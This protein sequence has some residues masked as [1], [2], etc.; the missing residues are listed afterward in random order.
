MEHLTE[1]A[2]LCSR[3][4]LCIEEHRE[5]ELAACPEQVQALLPGWTREEAAELLSLLLSSAQRRRFLSAVALPSCRTP[6][7]AEFCQTALALTH[8]CLLREEEEV[9][10]FAANLLRVNLR[11]NAAEPELLRQTAVSAM[12][13]LVDAEPEL[14][15][16][17]CREYLPH[18]VGQVSPEAARF[19]W[20]FGFSL[21]NCGEAAEAAQH[22]RRCMEL[23][24]KTEGPE[25]WLGA[26]AA[27]AWYSHRLAAGDEAAELPLWNILDGI[28][29]SLYKGMDENAPLVANAILYLVLSTRM[30]KQELRNFLPQIRRFHDFC[31]EHP[32]TSPYFTLRA[33]ENFLS[34]YHMEQGD[35]LQAARHAVNALAARPAEGMPAIPDDSL[36]QSNLLLIYSQ[37]GDSDQTARLLDILLEQLDGMDEDDPRIYRLCVLIHTTQ[38]RLGLDTSEQLPQHR[39][40]LE[41]YADA[42]ERGEIPSA[43]EDAVSFA[44]WILDLISGIL[45]EGEAAPHELEL[46]RR[47]IRH[48]LD[49]PKQ[50]PFNRVQQAAA[51]I[52]QAQVLQRLGDPAVEQALEQCLQCS[53]VLP[54]SHEVR[55]GGLRFAALVY[56]WLNKREK[57]KQ[58]VTEALEGVHCAWQKAMAYLND[59]KLYQLLN[60]VQLYFSVCCSLICICEGSTAAYEQVLRFKALG[61]RAGRERN[62]LLR[63]QPVDPE[64]T[65]EI[66]RLQD[67]LAAARFDLQ[68][69]SEEQ[70]QADTL[71]QQELEAEFAARFPKN[72]SF[73]PVSLEAVFDALPDGQAIAEYIFLPGRQLLNDSSTDEIWDLHLFLTVKRNGKAKLHHFRMEQGDR[74]MEQAEQLTALL[75]APGC[76]DP[77]RI[78]LQAGLYRRLL[79]PILPLLEDVDTLY[80]AP[81]RELCN[82][83]FE[84][85]SADGSGT[86]FD[87]F[88]VCRLVSGRDLLYAEEASSAGGCFVLGAP[89]YD[90]TAEKP[91]RFRGGAVR[92][93]PF[94]RIEAQR[95]AALCGTAA[96][97][98]PE[99]TKY[100]LRAAGPCRVIHLATHGGFD[101][102][103]DTESLYSSHLIFSGYNRR[104]EAGVEDPRWG[105]GV[106]TADEI[107]RMD[108][109]GTDLVVLS[110]CRSGLTDATSGSMQGLIS[111][112]SAA[113]AKWVVSHL[114]E[115]ND[116]ATPIFMDYFYE[117]LI[118][119]GA[120]VPDALRYARD[121]LRHVTIARLRQD[122]WL[123]LGEEQVGREAAE[124]IRALRLAH[125][126]RRP[127][128]DEA[129]W[130]GFV[131]HRCR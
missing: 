48:L 40:L 39:A 4:Q 65:A 121:K 38:K 131:V 115:A 18:F 99:A 118:R 75:Q 93:L 45:D 42:L 63:L 96:C 1:L 70:M 37:L 11:R 100:A 52:V 94:S 61:Q 7:R 19:F 92:N 28:D 62:R 83:P 109:H 54:E 98:G 116:F 127:F 74:I 60:L 58:C 64:L 53:R 49:H 120:E 22:F 56:Y 43:T 21:Q 34:G 67:R 86:V 103:S 35:F 46:Y 33:A 71:L 36:L 107:S 47:M 13:Y 125:D 128:A 105:N 130:G 110:A 108:L 82:L 80:L 112:F 26:R 24:Q 5:A 79:A 55:I 129:Y 122:G 23:C 123:D 31:R 113:G 20:Y 3:V 78:T 104:G 32:D 59:R 57:A 89:D 29:R 15:A 8:S 76:T 12:E 51:W 88:R 6:L 117:A 68:P 87:R 9:F 41:H 101:P 106:L 17:A 119:R 66:F 102:Q 50:F 91:D 81:D 69:G 84:I 124:Q 16:A 111:A 2:R 90:G 77:N 95:V 73:T 30:A 10:V 97:T 44:M 14:T 114:W 25:S 27:Q 126:R 85:L 72:C